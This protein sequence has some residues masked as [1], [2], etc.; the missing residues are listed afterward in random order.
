MNGVVDIP[1][2]EGR[3]GVS[4]DGRV[5]SFLTNKFL[6]TPIGKR[7]YPNVNLRGSDNK[8]KL[9]CVHRLVAITFIPNP[10]NLPEVNHIDGDKS[11]NNVSNL[12][13]CTSKHNNHHARSTGLHQS[14]GDKAVLQIKD[15]IVINR[16]KSASEASRKTGI[17]RANICNVCRGYVNK[18]KHTR[19][20]G[21]F[22]WKYDY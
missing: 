1:N 9:K 16:Y 8:C 13:W 5:Y 11:N 7:G 2:Y 15:G 12:E 10:D 20:A 18:G 14:D 17:G 19:T 4:K 3:Y 6:K 22:V 21:G